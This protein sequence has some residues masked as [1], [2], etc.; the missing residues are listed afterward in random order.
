VNYSV[1]LVVPVVG[2]RF[3]GAVPAGRARGRRLAPP[4]SRF[5][6]VVAA[7]ALVALSVNRSESL[8]MA[9]IVVMA[10]VVA[11]KLARGSAF[12]LSRQCLWPGSGNGNC[13]RGVGWHQRRR[14]ATSGDMKDR[15]N[16]G[17]SVRFVPPLD[18]ALERLVALGVRDADG[19]EVVTAV[20]WLTLH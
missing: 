5:A 14:P 1:V 13:A 7:P 16:L 4:R 15:P 3:A 17:S 6:G 9:A 10:R 12:S 19:L 20:L 2:V 18:E 11:I 8:P